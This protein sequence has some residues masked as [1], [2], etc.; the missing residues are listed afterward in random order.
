MVRIQSPRPLQRGS[1]SA[2]SFAAPP[3]AA[4]AVK[5]PIP[6]DRDTMDP[7]WLSFAIFFLS[8]SVFQ[9]V[10]FRKTKKRGHLISCA[11]TLVFAGWFV[12]LALQLRPQLNLINAGKEPILVT[13][14]GEFE[15]RKLVPMQALSV[16]YDIGAEL[17]ITR[18]TDAGP[19]ESKSF[20]LPDG[21]HKEVFAATARAVPGGPILVAFR[22]SAQK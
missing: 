2:A 22:N 8:A 11:T 17:T 16:L 14:E 5:G 21:K 15:M 12:F 20:P 4:C 18:I 7:V 19:G 10:K 13:V 9:L 1:L 6:Y 3:H